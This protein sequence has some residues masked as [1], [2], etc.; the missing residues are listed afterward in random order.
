[1]AAFTNWLA[2]ALTAAAI[3]YYDLVYTLWLKRRT[4][5]TPSGAASAGRRRCSS[6]GPR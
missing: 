6:A 1:M 4:P 2:T 3:V 5:R